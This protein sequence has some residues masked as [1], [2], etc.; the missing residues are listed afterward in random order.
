LSRVG[1]FYYHLKLIVDQTPRLY[2]L[3]SK[4]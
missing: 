1:V 2:N 3:P 4:S